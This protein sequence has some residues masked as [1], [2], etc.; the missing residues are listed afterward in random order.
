MRKLAVFSAAVLMAVSGGVAATDQ[1]CGD[2]KCSISQ[3]FSTAGEQ[4]MD[5]GAGIQH[6]TEE[7]TDFR[8]SRKK[9]NRALSPEEQGSGESK[10][11]DGSPW[12][13]PKTAREKGLFFSLG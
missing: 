13:E 8:E 1:G 7:N 9:I 6:L 5:I 3:F 4:I 12:V 11:S 2:I 10:S